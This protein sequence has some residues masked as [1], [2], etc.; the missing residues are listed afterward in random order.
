[1][2]ELPKNAY[3]DFGRLK[4]RWPVRGSGDP[5]T[6]SARAPS[7]TILPVW[8]VRCWRDGLRSNYFG[9]KSLPERAQVNYSGP[10]FKRRINWLSCISRSNPVGPWCRNWPDMTIFLISLDLLPCNCVCSAYSVCC[11]ATSA[12][13]LSVSAICTTDQYFCLHLDV[14]GK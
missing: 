5:C 4:C 3:M 1:M 6:A 2:L 8:F 7:L 13:H 9:S 10:G 14:S 12:R 11:S